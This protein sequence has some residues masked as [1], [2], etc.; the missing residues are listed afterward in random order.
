MLFSAGRTRHDVCRSK[1]RPERV[2]VL[3]ADGDHLGTQLPT[4]V[5]V[6]HE[7]SYPGCI[8]LD[9]GTAEWAARETDL[10]RTP[11]S[12]ALPIRGRVGLSS[13]GADRGEGDLADCDRV[14]G[15]RPEWRHRL[16]GRTRDKAGHTAFKMFLRQREMTLVELLKA[17]A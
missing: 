5:V 2:A 17:R 6:P 7:A 9:K 3:L 8:D 16:I 10:F 4:R 12:L 1:C 13:Q 11:Q 15:E 14:V